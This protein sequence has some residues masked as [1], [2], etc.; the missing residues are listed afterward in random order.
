M[1]FICH[2]IYFKFIVVLGLLLTH[3]CLSFLSEFEILSNSTFEVGKMCNYFHF[4]SSFT[5]TNNFTVYVV[6]I[7]MMR[8]EENIII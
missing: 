3:R 6:N 2:N 8:T 7:V 4:E 5:I 1:N